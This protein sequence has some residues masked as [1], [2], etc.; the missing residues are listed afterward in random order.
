MTEFKPHRVDLDNI[1]T[2]DIIH[3][4]RDGVL[5]FVL[6]HLIHWLKEP[7]WDMWDWHTTPIVYMGLPSAINDWCR[8]MGFTEFQ[9]V[10]YPGVDAVIVDAQYPRI[11]LSLLST[12]IN[13]KHQ[14]RCYR[15]LENEPTKPRVNTF[16]ARHL[17]KRY[18]WKVY[19]YTALA[20]F[21]RPVIDVPRLIDNS[22]DCWE[23]TFNFL[24]L[25]NFEA[26]AGTNFDYDYPWLPDLR[27]AYGEIPLEVR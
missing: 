26:D 20:K 5:A 17:N 21:L 24:E 19:I 25:F 7:E 18:D 11:K 22:Y 2:G 13:N 8:K 12:Y 15:L 16:V 4:K 14:C 3:W 6:A 9:F 27:R 1:Q 23:V 10:K